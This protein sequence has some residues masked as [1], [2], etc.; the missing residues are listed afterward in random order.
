[1]AAYYRVLPTGLRSV[2]AAQVHVV[3]AIL[4]CIAS[5]PA[6]G[7]DQRRRIYFLESLSPTQP[8]A[9]R[10]IEGFK[11]RLSEKT[12]ESF[13]IFIDYMELGRFPGQA[14]LDR[15]TQFLAGKYAEAPPDLLIL[16]GR[17]AIP[18]VFTHRDIVAPHVPIIIASVPA[19]ATAEAKALVNTVYVVT[20]YNFAKTLELARR[21]EPEARDLVFIAGASE[22]DRSWVDDARRELEPY[23]DRYRTKY[24][25][26]LPYDEM[27][28]AVSQLSRNTIVM[29]SF[30]FVD[31]TGQPR[32]PPDVAA[33]VANMSAAPVYS[34]VS[35]FFGRGVIGGYMD[36]YE[37]EGVAA[38]DL[39]FEI[40]S[41]KAPAALNQ[42]TKP[43]H[44]YEVDARQLER[45]GLSS[46]NL[47]SGTVVSFREPTI[48]EQH[49]NFVLAGVL[50]FALQ[51]GLVAV[52]LIQRRRRRR[53][54]VLL[55][56]SEERMTFTAASA[57][58]GL[59]QFNRET[60]ELW[61]TEHSRAMFGLAGDVPLTRDAF[62]AAIRPEDREAAIS[63]LR[64]A[65]N[66]NQSAITDVRVVLPD[67]QMRWIRIR[68]RSHPDGRV[69][70]NQLSGI[71]VDISDRKAAETDA[72]LQREA[73][74]HLMRVSVL[75][76]LSGAIAHEINQPLT[77]IQTN[78]Q[79][80][81]YLLAQNSPDLGEI[82]DVLEDI[83]HDNRRASDV[84]QRL[85]N[86]LK[87]GER[88]SERV[89]VNDLVNSTVALLNSELI[90]RRINVKLDLAS[91]LP[92]TLG[93]PI[94]L[95]QV[96]LNLVMNAMDAMAEAPAA[97]RL[98]TV[99]TRATP[100]GA[101]EVLVKDRGTG[102]NVAQQGR[103]FE[104]FYTT[105]TRGLGLGLTICSTI[106]EA[107]GGSLTLV[108][109]EG[110]G[111]IARFSLPVQELL[112]AAQ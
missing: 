88:R 15:T 54:E 98:V 63:S 65:L 17:A 71:F 76:Q 108:N 97:Q 60:G 66:A 32:V 74:A 30:V 83:V 100:T 20:E 92:L 103:P 55:K 86:L 26:G 33:A 75:G 6:A 78:A 73:V 81:L 47:P 62:L 105:K 85:R 96:L 53:V 14:H 101:V 112:I 77:A 95:Q 36:S 5:Q 44:R 11:K 45:W 46:R 50:I 7:D 37:A 61:T 12:T 57:N 13:E 40:L 106:V 69:T 80:G 91:A 72:T 28:K 25:V 23:L 51:T 41:G 107:H 19:R 82:H 109:G 3:V 52:L 35:T 34:P 87:K 48:W 99:S 39:A 10:T 79:T 59:W 89:D 84:I 16:L 94:Q 104:P 31:G 56:E 42:E 111:A 38:A 43:L 49:R 29:M 67:D 22:H 110:G 93:D 64:K 58:V 24:V 68:A 1:M 9:I 70:P 102:L 21:L 2:F 4:F 8:A 18:F 90:S 27:L